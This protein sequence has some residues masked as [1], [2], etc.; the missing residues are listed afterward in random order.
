MDK[1]NYSATPTAIVTC[2]HTLTT[3]TKLDGVTIMAASLGSINK[4]PDSPTLIINSGG[5]YSLREELSS[6]GAFHKLPAG[7]SEFGDRNYLPTNDADELYMDW[8]DFSA[9]PL[10]P[11]FWI[12]LWRNIVEQGYKNVLFTCTGGHGRTGTAMCSL[13]IAIRHTAAGAIELVRSNYCTGAVEND[14]QTQY[15]IRVSKFY[16]KIDESLDALNRIV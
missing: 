11:S 10:E 14:A 16:N 7:W 12:R 4:L 15:L 1:Y 2:K 8:R 6:G 13:L 9:P 3:V 5:K